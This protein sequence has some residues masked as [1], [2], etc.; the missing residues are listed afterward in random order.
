MPIPTC[1]THGPHPASYACLECADLERETMPNA[2]TKPADPD[3][4]YD[5]VGAIIAYEGGDLDDAG[6]LELF[7]HLVDTGMAWTLQGSYGRTASA[8]IDAGH[9]SPA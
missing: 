8:L 9:I 5:C 7:Q 6:T 1:K 3:T 2:Q 4:L